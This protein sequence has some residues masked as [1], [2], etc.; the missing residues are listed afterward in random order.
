MLFASFHPQA[1]LLLLKEVEKTCIV[2]QKRLDHLLVIT[3]H[4]V[5]IE[6]GHH[7]TCLRMRDRDK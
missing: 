4:L 2:T 7:Y 6:T 1:L 5:T 3:S